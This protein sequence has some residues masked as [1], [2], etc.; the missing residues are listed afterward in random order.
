MW[1]EIHWLYVGVFSGTR[2][3]IHGKE[4]FQIEVKSVFTS[5]GEKKTY[6]GQVL[7]DVIPDRLTKLSDAD[8]ILLRL[9]GKI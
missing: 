6:S 2:K 3:A 8:L 1:D 4:F 7:L 9:E 5:K